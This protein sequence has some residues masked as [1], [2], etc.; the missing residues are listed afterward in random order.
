M[1]LLAALGDYRMTDKE[2]KS[3][4]KLQMLELLHQ[5]EAEIAKMKSEMAKPG[6][7]PDSALLNEIL[8]GAQQA[9]DSY[10]KSVQSMENDKID[11]IAKL[12]NDARSRYEEA[13]RYSR[14]VTA[15]IR[16]KIVDMDNVFT[17]LKELVE[18]MHEEFKQ[19]LSSSSLGDIDGELRG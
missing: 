11:G 7:A 13:E 4:S 8:M 19:K 15:K 12:E 2:L 3:L 9:V 14:D 6:L 16:E 18:S 1:R 10:L 5:Q 17:G